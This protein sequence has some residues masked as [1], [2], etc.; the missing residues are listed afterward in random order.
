M[1]MTQFI[2]DTINKTTEKLMISLK[3]N[4]LIKSSDKT[5]F[6]KTEQLLYNYNGFK[7]AIAD[8]YEHI[9]TIKS[10]GMAQRSKGITV[11]PSNPQLDTRSEMEKC[12]D[13]I[14]RL[15]EVITKT[16]EYI[17]LIDAALD[18]VKMDPY[19]KIIEM[20]YFQEMTREDIAY[21]LGVDVSTVTRNKNRLLNTLGIF[22]FSEDAI[23][24]MFGV[25]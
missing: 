8:K 5:A 2:E 22:L 10:D 19:F 7:R 25:A 1:D 12:E 9:E 3:R 21:E 17:E 15:N 4:N 14:E 24:E 23:L 13:K 16:K 20:K 18:K 6:Q 11:I